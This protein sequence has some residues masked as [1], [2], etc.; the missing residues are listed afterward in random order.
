MVAPS[1]G[2]EALPLS[3]AWAPWSW[4]SQAAGTFQ[5]VECVGVNLGDLEGRNVGEPASDRSNWRFIDFQFFRGL[6]QV[7]PICSL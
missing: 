7:L 6:L 3:G 2:F 4:R 1:L 5:I